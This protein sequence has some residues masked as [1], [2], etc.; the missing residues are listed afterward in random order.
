MTKFYLLIDMDWKNT[1]I[2]ILGPI[3]EIEQ[4]RAS[5]FEVIILIIIIID[6]KI[7]HH[8]LDDWLVLNI[9]SQYLNIAHM[10]LNSQILG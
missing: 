5:K 7:I 2:S 8:Q 1:K 9:L 6:I 3:N 4:S 10:H